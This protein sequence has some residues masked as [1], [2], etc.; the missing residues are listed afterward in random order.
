MIRLDQVQILFFFERNGTVFQLRQ[1]K[2]VYVQGGKHSEKGIKDP[3]C[4]WKHHENTFLTVREGR[5]LSVS[6][7][8]LPL[9]DVLLD[10]CGHLWHRLCGIVKNSPI[11]L[12]SNIPKCVDHY[13]I[14]QFA[15]GGWHFFCCF[16]P[17][18]LDLDRVP[19][20]LWLQH[21]KVLPRE[22][23]VPDLLCKWAAQTKV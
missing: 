10:S 18:C 2:R 19:L 13:P 14:E 5:L 6:E 20:R 7:S 16:F 1:E 15:F 4:A 8:P 22:D 23:L 21:T 11:S 3:R 12:F 9:L 17:P